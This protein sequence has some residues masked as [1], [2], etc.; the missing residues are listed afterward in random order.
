MGNPSQP[1]APNETAD[2]QQATEQK[3]AAEKAAAE[4]A[5]AQLAAAK[6]AEANVAVAEAAVA[7]LRAA[8]ALAET[9]TAEARAA[10]TQV[11][12]PKLQ[13]P[14]AEPKLRHEFVG[15]MFAL[16]IGE[17]AVQTGVLIRAGN[18]VHFLPA[19]SHL[20]LTAMLIAASWVGW[21]LSPSPG[22]R[23]DVQGVFQ[24]GFLVLLIDVF[25]VVVYFILA[26]TVDIAGEG[27]P[28][29]NASAHPEAVWILVIF[30]TYLVWDILTKIVVYLGERRTEPW[31]RNYGSRMIPTIICLGLAWITKPLFDSA[32]APHVL[33]ADLALLSL[34]MLFRAL[35]GLVD[36]FT[37][38]NI[39]RKLPFAWTAVCFLGFAL[40]TIWT[41]SYPVP[42]FIA[43]QI[44]AT[45]S[46][47]SPDN[48]KPSAKLPLP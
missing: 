30:A 2:G 38:P 32:D 44:L 29:L 21:T 13:E 23:K 45:P 15:M 36:S 26:K 48:Q 43:D 37:K 11:D 24:M 27:S 34:V 12:A 46:E 17:V 3:A 41:S 14:K 16:A 31:F 19:Y 10:A 39:P 9:K 4:R 28:K 7:Q 5:A 42:R 1:N 20:F 8:Q 33:T 25:L 22:A 18:W 47:P 6:V 40:G 35:K